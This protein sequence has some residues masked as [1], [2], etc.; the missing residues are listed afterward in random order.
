VSDLSDHPVATARRELRLLHT[1]PPFDA[2]VAQSVLELLAVGGVGLTTIGNIA[3]YPAYWIINQ[4]R[5]RFPEFDEACVIASQAG[6]DA[7]AFENLQIADCDKRAPA[8]KALSIAVR[9][10]LSKV[11][12]RKKYDPATKI[13]V[14]AGAGRADDLSDDELARIARSRARAG[15]VDVVTTGEGDDETQ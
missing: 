2:D 7:L 13:E 6:A 12:N 10:R 11:L 8:N 4:W 3:G 1:E 5:A 15:A 14:S 9:E